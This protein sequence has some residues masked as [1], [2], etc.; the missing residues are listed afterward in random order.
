[1]TIAPRDPHSEVVD[2]RRRWRPEWYEWLSELAKILTQLFYTGGG[3][4][5]NLTVY[6]SIPYITFFDKDFALSATNPMWR[7]R[8]FDDGT[9]LIQNS[10]D[11]T[12]FT[13]RLTIT[14][15]GAVILPSYIVST[16]PSD[17]VVG[18]IAV[19]TDATAT[20][21]NSV[22]AGTGSDKVLVFYDGT[23]WRIG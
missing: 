7:V 12:N 23:N 17:A 15:E 21:Q 5:P 3:T 19:V 20:T 11:G 22:V 16:L 6:S 13:T 9:F 1:M 14:A 4:V 8:A 10:P 2:E 18:A